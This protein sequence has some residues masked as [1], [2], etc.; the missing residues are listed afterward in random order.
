MGGNYGDNGSSAPMS[1]C[2][3]GNF[4]FGDVYVGFRISLY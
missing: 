3:G 2:N 1:G 4:D